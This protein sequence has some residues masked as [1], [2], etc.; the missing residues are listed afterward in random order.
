MHGEGTYVWPDIQQ[1]Y[2][3]EFKDGKRHGTGC[4]YY[5][6]ASPEDT[7]GDYYD[8]EWKDGAMHG[9]ARYVDAGGGEH[10]GVWVEGVCPEVDFTHVPESGNF[11][12]C[13]SV[14]ICL[15]CRR[16]IGR[17][18]DLCGVAGFLI[19]HGSHSVLFFQRKLG[20]LLCVAS[21]FPSDL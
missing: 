2:V 14:S 13:F 18:E 21:S 15:G 7:V 10:E 5:S 17:S 19:F 8:G 6:S 9:K 12:Y 20:G 11:R 1:C 3:G 16:V 4:H